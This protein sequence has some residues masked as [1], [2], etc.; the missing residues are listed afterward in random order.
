MF[1]NRLELVKNMMQIIH[2]TLILCASTGRMHF[3]SG[4]DFFEHFGCLFFFII[5]CF[6]FKVNS[7]VFVHNSVATLVAQCVTI[8]VVPPVVRISGTVIV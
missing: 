2:I 4:F 3:K 5:V 6:F 7:G 1:K 8:G